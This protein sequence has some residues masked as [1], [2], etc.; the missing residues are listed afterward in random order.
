MPNV[1]H[2]LETALYVDDLDRSESFYCT[3]FGCRT[4]MSDG[5]MRAVGIADGQ[6][7]LLFERGK[8][9]DG[10]ATPRGM[11]PGHDG[12]GPL[13]LALAI[14]TADVAAWREHL[15]DRGIPVESHVRPQQGG[16]SLYFRDPDGHLIELA[17]PNIWNV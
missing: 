10:E 15:A 17:T 1:R 12:H 14:D 11:I 16:D 8:S 6:M 4:K 5:R 3:V 7:L 13:H 9:V 2:I